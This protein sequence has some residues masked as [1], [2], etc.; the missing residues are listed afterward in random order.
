[1]QREKPRETRQ[2][3]DGGGSGA[4]TSQHRGWAAGGGRKVLPRSRGREHGLPHLGSPLPVSRT[5]REQTSMALS[6]Q[7]P[8]NLLQRP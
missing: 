4:A 7:V 5:V 3:R 6:Q 2:A 1:M 8:D